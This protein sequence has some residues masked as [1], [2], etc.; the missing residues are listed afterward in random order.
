M[1]ALLGLDNA[2]GGR[3]EIAAGKPKMVRISGKK[4]LE[5]CGYITENRHFDGGFL[6]M[7]I[8]KRF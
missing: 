8:Y 7:P 1:R 3:R 2:S 5:R 6:G 4:L